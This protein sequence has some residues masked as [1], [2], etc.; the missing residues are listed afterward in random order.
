MSSSKSEPQITPWPTLEVGE[1]KDY[2]VFGVRQVMRR[3]PRTGQAGRYQVL[4]TA[5]WVNVVA[6]TAEGE[7]VLI[8]QYRHGIDAITVEIPGGMVDP[9]EDPAAAAARELAEETGYTG[10]APVKLGV[11]HPN[12]AIQ[13]NA[14]STW[15]ITGARWTTE[16]T[17]DPGEHI[18]VRTVPRRELPELLRRGE[19][20]HSLVIVA[21]HWLD[22]YDGGPR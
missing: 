17:P 11:V 15:L 13:T 21:F 1:M 20:T 7:V 5:D 19:I 6:L 22:L 3:S 12:P 14:C 18:A 8:E 16:P 2:G 4:S 9:G 10:A